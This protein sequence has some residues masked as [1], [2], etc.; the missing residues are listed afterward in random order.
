M[1]GV[2]T[3]RRTARVLRGTA[4]LVD[5]V[6]SAADGFGAALFFYD[7]WPPA[8]RAQ[9]DGLLRRL[10]ADGSVKATVASM[11]PPL[12]EEFAKELLSFAAALDTVTQ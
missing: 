5:R 10:L 12:A 7:T 2:E 6:A 9:A 1:N 4:P 8:L 3:M 11:N